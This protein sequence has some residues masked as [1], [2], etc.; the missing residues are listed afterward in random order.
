MISAGI[1]AMFRRHRIGVHAALMLLAFIT[2]YPFLFLLVNSF[3]S[4][5]Q[6][7]RSIWWFEFPLHPRNYAQAW[8]AVAPYI[9]NSVRVALATVTLTVTLS[10]FSGYAFARFEFPGKNTLYYGILVLLMIPA[11]LVIVPL[12]MQVRRFGLI[13]T[14][15]SLILPYSSGFQAFAV[16]IMRGFFASL[17]REL[18]EAARIDGASEFLILRRIVVPLSR[19]VVG[20]VALFIGLQVWNDYVFP[21]IMVSERTKRTIPVGLMAFRGEYAALENWGGLFA[22]YIIAS[23][24][25]VLL[26]LFTMR[27]FMRGLLAGAVKT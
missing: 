7:Y 8:A 10:L 3:K 17:P 9:R 22:G 12:F 6:F 2:F 5:E 16:L 18:F 11:F 24:P 23:V 21:L 1:G 20:T 26:F 13:N 25:M 27:Y 19:S 15:W 14:H 4:A